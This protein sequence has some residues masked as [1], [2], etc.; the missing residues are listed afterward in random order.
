MKSSKQVE[1]FIESIYQHFK[2][3]NKCKNYKELFYTKQD[4]I[5]FFETDSEQELK[6]LMEI[7]SI[8]TLEVY[9]EK[10]KKLIKIK[11]KYKENR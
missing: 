5:T 4:L 11:L 7:I 1:D 3:K 8:V 10:I 6:T 2:G 9:D